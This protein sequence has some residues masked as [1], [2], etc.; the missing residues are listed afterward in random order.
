MPETALTKKLC[1]SLVATLLTTLALSLKIPPIARAATI[2]V[3]S[4]ADAVANDGQCTLREAI[5]AANTDT[6][7]GS[8]TGECAAGL[9]DDTIDLTVI[10]G[11]I[12]LSG[13][14][15]DIIS[16]VVF[17]C[18]SSQRD[19]VAA[20]LVD[21]E[22]AVLLDETDVFTYDFSTSSLPEPAIIE[23]PRTT[24]EGLAGRTV[25]IEYRD[26]YGI[27]VEASTMWL[28]WRP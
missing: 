27:V 24:V 12:N 4:T 23:M 18:F 16:N 28:I 22:L 14:L 26:V 13:L 20:V 5:I 19:A 3:S 8:T 9:G 21:D 1:L 10:T 7:S 11:T 15:P 6:A 25:T 17:I 2:T